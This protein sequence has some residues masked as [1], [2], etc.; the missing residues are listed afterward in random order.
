MSFRTKLEWGTRSITGVL[1]ELVGIFKKEIADMQYRPSVVMGT[2]G[3]TLEH[4]FTSL[5]F[6]FE[7]SFY[8]TILYY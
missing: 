5:L 4:L 6:I 7:K 3:F 1:G 8:R 2:A